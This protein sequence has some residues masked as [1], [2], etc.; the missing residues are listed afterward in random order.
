MVFLDNWFVLGT[1]LFWRWP[2]GLSL[3]ISMVRYFGDQ[4][5]RL[6]S[7]FHSFNHGRLAVVTINNGDCICGQLGFCFIPLAPL[8]F[9]SLDILLPIPSKP[10][11]LINPFHMAIRLPK[12]NKPMN[13]LLGNDLFV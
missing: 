3:L 11:P 6:R 8:Y 4:V 9:T 13:A 12:E 5:T 10:V 1:P 2:L 7:N